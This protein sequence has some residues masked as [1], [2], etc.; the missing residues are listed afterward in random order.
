MGMG[1]SDGCRNDTLLM[2][3]ELKYIHIH[4]Y[5]YTMEQYYDITF[6]AYRFQGYGTTIRKTISSPS[7]SINNP[8]LTY[9]W[10]YVSWPYTEPHT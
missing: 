3:T 1:G 9:I 2:V 8:W 7:A 4:I 5:V 6:L 10:M